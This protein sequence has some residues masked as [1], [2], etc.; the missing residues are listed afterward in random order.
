MPA[1]RGWCAAQRTLGPRALG[2][3]GGCRFARALG[4]R[5]DAGVCGEGR[6]TASWVNRL[7]MPYLREAMYLVGKTAYA[8]GETVDAGR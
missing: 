8:L 1:G 7:L 2:A 3:R 5:K 6:A 4:Q